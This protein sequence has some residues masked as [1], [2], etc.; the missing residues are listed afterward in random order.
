MAFHHC[1]RLMSITVDPDS[2]TYRSDGSNSIVERKTGRLV[3]GCAAT[4]FL[5]EVTAIGPYAFVSTPEL[6]VLPEGIRDIGERAF[7]WSKSLWSVVIPRSVRHIGYNAFSRC[8]RLFGKVFMG[9]EVK[10]D[11]Y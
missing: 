4:R 11:E 1:E 3:L 6:L 2:K 10:E 7:S 8:D 9:D 5:P